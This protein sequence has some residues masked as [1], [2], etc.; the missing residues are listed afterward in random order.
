MLVTHL[1]LYKWENEVTSQEESGIEARILWFQIQRFYS[2]TVSHLSYKGAWE[3]RGGVT[4][5]QPPQNREGCRRGACRVPL[6]APVAWLRVRAAASARPC[7]G[8]RPEPLSPGDSARDR[9]AWG[10]G[11]GGQAQ[12]APRTSRGRGQIWEPDPPLLRQKKK[13]GSGAS[14][15]VLRVGAFC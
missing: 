14:M 13:P 1:P 5:P 11:D 8:H 12:E 4:K 10:W 2:C 6:A 9:S 7:W 15:W 3:A